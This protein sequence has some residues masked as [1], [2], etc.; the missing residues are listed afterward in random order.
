MGGDGGPDR[1]LD[2]FLLGGWENEDLTAGFCC[3]VPEPAHPQ[4]F[5]GRM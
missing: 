3:D 1:Q 5:L 4:A 2:R